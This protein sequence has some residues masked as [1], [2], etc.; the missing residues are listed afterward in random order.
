MKTFTKET[1]YKMYFQKI[2]IRTDY[3]NNRL[4]SK[5][6]ESKRENEPNTLV[7]EE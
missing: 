1:Y 7:L 3:K 4:C 6:H 5:I 2:V